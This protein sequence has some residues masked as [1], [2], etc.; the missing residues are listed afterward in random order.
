MSG[1]NIDLGIDGIDE[2]VMIGQGGFGTVYRAQQPAFRRTVAVKLLSVGTVDDKTRRAF[3]NERALAGSLSDHPGIV[4]VFDAGVNRMG[5]LYLVMA[6]MSGGSLGDVISTRGAPGWN[7]AVCVGAQVGAALQA[8]H[9][10]QI[11]HRDI[12][13]ANILLSPFQRAM[14]ADFGISRIAD[15]PETRSAHIKASVLYA[16]PRCSTAA[17]PSRPPTSTRSAPRCSRP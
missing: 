12:K 5:Q 2:A 15:A 8:A 9:D 4:T 14:I 13:P 1:R 7:A 17:S 11:V 10:R 16:G 3:E 6:Y